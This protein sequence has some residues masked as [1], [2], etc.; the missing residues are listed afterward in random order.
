MKKTILLFCVSLFLLALH[1]SCNKGNNS[2]IGSNNDLI[3]KAKT[4]FTQTVLPQADEYI[5]NQTVFIPTLFKKPVWDKAHLLKLPVAD[6][7]VVPLSYQNKLLVHS[8]F[9]SS[10]TVSLDDAAKL[11]IYQTADKNYH[12]EVVTG[13][14]DSTNIENENNFFGFVQ[15]EDWLGNPLHNYFNSAKDG[16]K[17]LKSIPGQQQSTSASSTKQENSNQKSRNE[18]IYVQSQ[19]CYTFFYEGDGGNLVGVAPGESNNYYYS[20]EDCFTSTTVIEIPE[21]YG[22]SISGGNYV[23]VSSGGGSSPTSGTTSVDLEPNLNLTNNDPDIAWWTDNTTTFPPQS[24]PCWQQ[25]YTNYPKSATGDDLPGPQVYQLVGG[26]VYSLYNSNPSAYQNAC[27][28]RVSRALN[29]SGVTIPYIANQ[30]YTGS[31]GKYYFLSSAKLF[32]W[33][34]KT[35]GAGNIVMTQSQGG[36][37]GA[38]FQSSLNGHQGIFIMQ[39]ALPASFGALGHASLF[40]GTTCVGGHCYLNATGGVA[41]VRLWVLPN[42]P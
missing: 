11:I 27:A 41:Q 17:E 10:N 33:M 37:N 18:T 30:T 21:T 40:N 12:A 8:N 39:A 35:F 26:Q 4:Y 9:S 15:V 34:R 29:H 28:L 20:Y 42:C 5:K 24:L 22:G 13:F 3:E 32:N 1:F 7:V 31:D 2:K 16:L 19:Q 36:V 25:M 14:P 38:N 6:V 23:T